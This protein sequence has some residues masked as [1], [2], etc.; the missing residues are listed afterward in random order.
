MEK[1]QEM[2][3]NL[4]NEI[5]GFITS[6]SSAEE[7]KKYQNLGTKVDEIQA[8]YDKAETEIKGLKE[9]IVSQVKDSGTKKTP[10]EDKP[11]NRSLDDIIQQTGDN[12]IAKRK[13]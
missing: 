4:K 9:I 12:I 10:D 6:E 7:I 8:E 2:I 3:Q 11:D 13:D 5:N 1:F